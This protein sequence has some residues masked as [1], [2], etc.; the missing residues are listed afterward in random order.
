M[1]WTVW[2]T[3]FLLA[4]MAGTLIFTRI[5]P[6]LVM[7]SLVRNA[8]RLYDEPDGVLAGRVSIHR[9]LALRWTA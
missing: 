7:L 2:T 9:L 4:V 1:H 5:G 6:D 8:N 3:L